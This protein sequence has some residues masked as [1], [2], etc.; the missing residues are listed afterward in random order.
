MTM[1]IEQEVLNA[2]C[3]DWENLEQMYRSIVF[4]F[5]SENYDP[6]NAQTYCWRDRQSGFTLANIADCVA[7]LVETG[8]LDARTEDGGEINNVK[9]ESIMTIWFKSSTIG[10]EYLQSSL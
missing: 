4:E 7:R 3:D 8:M 1:T 2:A 10:M 5:F 9:Y 6:A